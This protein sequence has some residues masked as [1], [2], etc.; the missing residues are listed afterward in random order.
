MSSTRAGRDR[1]ASRQAASTPE[2]RTRRRGP[3]QPAVTGS[4]EAAATATA[5]ELFE[6]LDCTSGGLTG[7]EA[8]Q[9][10]ERYGPNALPE[11]H[12]SVLRRLFGYFWGPIPWMIEIAAILSAAVRHWEDLVAI[13]VLL[14]FNALVGFVQEYQASNAVEALKQQLALKARALR[15]GRWGEVDAAYFWCRGM[16]SGCGWGM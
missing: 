10:M 9:R 3:T 2:R 15:D 16:W 13:L 1:D 6:S 7:A 5:R 11:E 8:A 12:V 14:V 4:L